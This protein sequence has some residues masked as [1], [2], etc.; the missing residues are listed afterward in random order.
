MLS[1]R[2]DAADYGA[3]AASSERPNIVNPG[4]KPYQSSLP[5]AAVR[6]A[7]IQK[8]QERIEVELSVL[9]SRVR[10]PQIPDTAIRGVVIEQQEELRSRGKE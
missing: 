10:D 8:Q 3:G 4:L 5:P 7:T 9:R 6:S 1:H 2:L